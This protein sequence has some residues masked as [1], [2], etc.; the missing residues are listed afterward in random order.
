MPKLKRQKPEGLEPASLQRDI[1]FAMPPPPTAL[2]TRGIS[3]AFD[4]PRLESGMLGGLEESAFVF[5][6]L[7]R[8]VAPRLACNTVVCS[9]FLVPV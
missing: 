9:F 6:S 1:S 4:L 2:G 5:L 3:E 7:L 8:S